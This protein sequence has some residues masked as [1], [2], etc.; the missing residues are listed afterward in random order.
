[1]SGSVTE[2]NIKEIARVLATRRD[3]NRRTVLFLGA[4]AGGLFGNGYLYE[5]LKQFSFLNFDNPSILNV[6]KFRECYYVLNKRFTEVERHNILVGAL[7]A[8][9]YREEDKILAELVKAGLFEVIIST[10]ID[11]LLEEAC[12]FWGMRNPN[13]YQVFI[14]GVDDI[15]EIEQ[16]KPRYTS[17]IKVC[18]DLESLHYNMMGGAIDLQ[19]E[20]GLQE[21]LESKLSREVL[22]LGYDPT[23]DQ[24]IEQA[25]SPTGE[26]VWYI[27]ETELQPNTHFASIFAQRNGKFLQ[28][29]RGS[30][31][32]FL[33]TL[34]DCL[35]E[36]IKWEEV[37]TAPHPLMPQSP[38]QG[39][40]RVFISYSHQDRPYLE[41]LTTHLKGYMLKDT[42]DIWDDMK[43]L[44]GTDWTK[45]IKRALAQAKVAVLLVSNHYLSSDFIRTYELPILLEAAQRRDVQLLPIIIEPSASLFNDRELLNQYQVVNSSSKPLKWMKPYEQ[46]V[47]WNKLAEQVYGILRSQK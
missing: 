44:L 35:G 6:D 22:I 16:D 42:V 40:K 13:D 41:R 17:I 4:R 7:A 24:P 31:S 36:E 14:P 12:S 37:A 19:A 1:M 45:E 26:T 47:V 46:E 43:I 20:K 32:S 10:N 5:M 21:L 18:G 11:T 28:S 8:L 38:G 39:K 9:G 34:H 25:F 15:A 30:Y 23:W 29:D 33:Q 3:Q 27:N 2:T